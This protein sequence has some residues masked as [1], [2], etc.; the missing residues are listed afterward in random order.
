MSGG[1]QFAL[2][3]KQASPSVSNFRVHY[4]SASHQ[5]FTHISSRGE[6]EQLG[7][8]DYES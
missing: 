4:K 1:R 8:A 3:V 6:R 7:A 5:P 2:G